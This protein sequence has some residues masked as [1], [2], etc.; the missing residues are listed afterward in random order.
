MRV[1]SAA[2]CVLN[3]AA[4]IREYLEALILLRPPLSVLK[5]PSAGMLLLRMLTVPS[6]FL[7][8]HKDV[9]WLAGAIGKW[10]MFQG[11]RRRGEEVEGNPKGKEQKE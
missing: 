6:G 11:G 2:L 5:T 3:E 7:Y 4:C 1:A 8:L 10:C 9:E